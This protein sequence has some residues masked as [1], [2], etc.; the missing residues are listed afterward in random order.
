MRQLQNRITKSKP[1]EKLVML[2]VVI[3][4]GILGVYLLVGSHAA[5]PFASL[6]ADQGT[7]ACGAATSTDAT[8]K[9]GNKVVFNG[10]G[11][12]GGTSSCTTHL[13]PASGMNPLTDINISSPAN[14]AV[15]CITAGTYGNLSI[16]GNNTARVM[17]ETD[18]SL[19]PNTSGK[20]QLTGINIADNF[21]TVHNFYSAGS[22]NVGSGG[23]YPGYHDDTIDHNAVG[24]THGDGITVFSANTTPSNTIKITN[25]I[26]HDTNVQGEG[27]AFRFDGW[28][29]ITVTG[30][31]LYHI[32]E[33]AG[34]GCHTDTLQSYNAGTTATGLTV[35]NN[36]THDN[37]GAQGL[38]FLHDGG[39]VNVTISDNL[40]LRNSPT[41]DQ[42]TGIWTDESVNNLVIT[43]NT[44]LGTS[45]SI[46]QGDGSS[47][48]NAPVPTFGA[49][50]NNIFDLFK[51]RDGG[52]PSY[53][54]SSSS[55]EDN[56]IFGSNN[57]T[58]NGNFK[59][60]SHSMIKTFASTAFM[61][62]TTGGCNGTG[63][64][65]TTTDPPPPAGD[66]YRLKD[67]ITVGGQTFTPGIDWSPA[68][69]HYG[70][71]MD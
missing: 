31:E 61:C 2:I 19:D 44:Y 46:V 7:L 9:D 27:D 14:G 32:K 53:T 30:N 48:A 3:A 29:N 58:T 49:L 62:S 1:Q 59:L 25:N 69:Q 18:P 57:G 12:G 5:T 39:F 17:I 26:I 38:P 34:S 52:G 35:T 70:P 4:V 42:V 20:V 54:F 67:P 28:N 50:N 13:S 71:T 55:P 37:I 45:G 47:S 51:V 40:S 24:P 43:K 56:D 8:A 21:V 41:N 22:V 66:D 60:G 33:C 63:S 23:P 65:I 36:Y 64:P 16:T 10:G 11:C 68:D 6:N 15:I